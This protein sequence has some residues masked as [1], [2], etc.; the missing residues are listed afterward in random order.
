MELWRFGWAT[1][2]LWLAAEPPIRWAESMAHS[3]MQTSV[4]AA[5]LLAF[6]FAV[7]ATA[8]PGRDYQT[9]ADY[10]AAKLE[11]A[12]RG[13]VDR[14]F[15]T[16]LV[17]QTQ[18]KAQSGEWSAAVHT[19]EPL[20]EMQGI[21]HGSESPELA[22][23]LLMLADIYSNLDRL[24]EAQASLQR[25]VSITRKHRAANP[26]AHIR[27]LNALGATYN[28]LSAPRDAEPV[29]AEA[30]ELAEQRFGPDSAEVGV[31]A[32]LLA[33]SYSAQ[34]KAEK[35]ASLRDRAERLLPRNRPTE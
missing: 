34:G 9:G 3:A 27:S 6:G 22:D 13:Q 8:E 24:P 35:A 18:L 16:F 4:L 26:V 31:T 30:L 14:P 2:A 19:A 33:S 12:R 7:T 15:L 1:E 29:L 32:W 17:V 11:A 5:A 20:V 23:A 25:S 10:V 28:L 21:V